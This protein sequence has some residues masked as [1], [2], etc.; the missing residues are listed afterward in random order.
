MKHAT[1]YLTSVGTGTMIS[2]GLTVANVDY[3]STSFRVGQVAI[4]RRNFLGNHVTCRRR[5][6]WATTA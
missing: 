2:D 5:A 1:P 3:S 6:G 4:G